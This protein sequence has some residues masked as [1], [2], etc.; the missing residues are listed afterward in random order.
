MLCSPLIFITYY[1]IFI[2][3]LQTSSECGQSLK[4]VASDR[5]E[6]SYTLY[7]FEG[8]G[9][10]TREVSNRLVTLLYTEQQAVALICQLTA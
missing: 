10:V 2:L 1:A 7:D 9:H 5:Q 6:W 8:Q 3:F 4:S